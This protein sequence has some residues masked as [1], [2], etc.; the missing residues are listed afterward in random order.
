M[1]DFT[2][3][4]ILNFF[5]VNTVSTPGNVFWVGGARQYDVRHRPNYSTVRRA[6]I[7]VKNARRTNEP[8]SIDALPRHLAQELS[9]IDTA[10]IGEG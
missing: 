4:A 3:S 1:A 10:Q 5:G 9:S 6:I 2:R 7:S 8:E